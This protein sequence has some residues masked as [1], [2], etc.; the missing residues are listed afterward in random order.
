MCYPRPKRELAEP[1]PGLSKR[2]RGRA[3]PKAGSNSDPRRRHVC[4]VETCKKMFIKRDHLDRHIRSLHRHDLEYCLHPTCSYT[5]TRRDNM[6][7]HH[8]AHQCYQE[9]FLCSPEDN[10]K[11]LRLMNPQVA[12]PQAVNIKPFSNISIHPMALDLWIFRENQRR[13]GFDLP[14][15]DFC[16]VQRYFNAH[17]D[18]VESALRR[19]PQWEWRMP[20]AGPEFTPVDERCMTGKFKLDIKREPPAEGSA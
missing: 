4:P 14:V 1:V 11:G 20:Q 8:G 15:G 6:S 19:D 12:R 7:A 13:N 9:I 16:D 18:E 17:P 10:F 2:A 3:V 5:Y